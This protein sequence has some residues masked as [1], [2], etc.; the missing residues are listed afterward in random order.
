MHPAVSFEVFPSGSQT[1]VCLSTLGS[2]SFELVIGG[3]S[4]EVQTLKKL[5]ASSL[6]W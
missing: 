4:Y 6:D 1:L 3:I 2:P 5:A